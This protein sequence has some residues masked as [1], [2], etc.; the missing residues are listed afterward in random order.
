MHINGYV[1]TVTL[2]GGHRVTGLGDIVRELFL[3]Y[4]DTPTDTVAV[5]LDEADA[6]PEALADPADAPAAIEAAD[7]AP[8]PDR[9]TADEPAAEQEIPASRTTRWRRR[10]PNPAPTTQRAAD[11][12]VEAWRAA[13]ALH[14]VGGHEVYVRDEPAATADP[15]LPPLLVLHGFPTNSYDFASRARRAVGAGGG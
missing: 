15:T 9:P 13:G 8:A 2:G 4:G 3:H 14:D 12:S 6:A 7:D 11:M 10:P 1:V 5:P